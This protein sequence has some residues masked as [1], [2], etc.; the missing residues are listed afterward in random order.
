MEGVVSNFSRLSAILPRTPQV[1][2]SP[3]VARRL[4]MY[5]TRKDLSEAGALA[6]FMANVVESTHEETLRVLAA[7]DVKE[8]VDRV[9]EILQRQISSIQ[10]STRMT[11]TTTQT[12]G[13]SLDMDTLRRLQ[14][15]ALARRGSRIPGVQE[16]PRESRRDTMD[17]DDCR[18]ARRANTGQGEEAARR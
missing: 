2:L 13:G 7:V 10:G 18:P 15:E 16:L 9:I 12:Q 14:Q 17:Q 11:V 5:I 4:E 6:D 1:T 8:R 3:I